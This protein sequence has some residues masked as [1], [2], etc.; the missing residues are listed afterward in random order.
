A[1]GRGFWG[2][3][4]LDQSRNWETIGNDAFRTLQLLTFQFARATNG[5]DPTMPWQLNIARFL[6][7][8]I[9]LLESYRLVLGAIRSPARLAMIGLRH[10]HIVVVPGR[11][12]NGLALLREGRDRKLRAIA[13]AP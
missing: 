9:A 13:A 4:W 1:L 3:G 10:G 12:P 7:P 8:A 11:G 6:V 5:P 2:W